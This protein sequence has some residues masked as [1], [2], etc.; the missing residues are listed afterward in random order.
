M[1][2]Y[3]V[4]VLVL[5]WGW[6]GNEGTHCPEFKLF[7]QSGPAAESENNIDRDRRRRLGEHLSARCAEAHQI[8]VVP[9]IGYKQ[10]SHCSL[11][12][13]FSRASRIPTVP[14][15][16]ISHL[17]PLHVLCTL[18]PLQSWTP[19]PLPSMSSSSRIPISCVYQASQSS[20][21]SRQAYQYLWT[22]NISVTIHHTPIVSSH[23]PSTKW[24]MGSIRIEAMNNL[25]VNCFS[26]STC[27]ILTTLKIG[28]FKMNISRAT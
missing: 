18:S 9:L 26:L 27:D 10:K 15:Q 23:E 13:K 28:L 7:K 5:F 19:L 25:W 20:T 3:I 4:L 6:E 2:L 21:S 12:Y 22:T 14:T 16:F 1:I 8:Q 11:L 17:R 24:S